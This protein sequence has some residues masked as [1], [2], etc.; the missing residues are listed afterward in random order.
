M[1]ARRLIKMASKYQVDLEFDEIT[2]TKFSREL[3]QDHRP[4]TRPSTEHSV[5]IGEVEF[6]DDT[7]TPNEIIEVLDGL[8][9]HRT[10]HAVLL[11]RGVREYL[12]D[13]L[14]ARIKRGAVAVA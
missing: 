13:T 5:A 8:A 9:Y 7:M 1:T 12:C 11:D 14:R 10:Q 4:H 2:A 3:D 6:L